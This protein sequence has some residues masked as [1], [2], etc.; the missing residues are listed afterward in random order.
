MTEKQTP[1]RRNTYQLGVLDAEAERLADSFKEDR[2]IIAGRLASIGF[3]LMQIEESIFA[4]E[5]IEK[6]AFFAKR[7]IR[8]Y[9]FLRCIDETLAGEFCKSGLHSYSAGEIGR[10]MNDFFYLEGKMPEF[11]YVRRIISESVSAAIKWENDIDY[12]GS[13]RYSCPSKSHSKS[14]LDIIR[15]VKLKE[16]L[17]GL[18]ERVCDVACEELN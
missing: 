1:K 2:E 18:F 15:A 8:P 10:R 16:T 14:R 4:R 13:R 6:F 12:S 5:E 17:D 3:Q 9:S 11:S 7:Y